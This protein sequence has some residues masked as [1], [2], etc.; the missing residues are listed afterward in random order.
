MDITT[1]RTLMRKI[2]S[3]FG[4]LE[5]ENAQ[6]S[7]IERDLMLSY[8]RQL[9][10]VFLEGK[11]PEPARGTIPPAEAPREIKVPP[12]QVIPP[13]PAPTPVP[14]AKVAKEEIPAPPPPPVMPK[15]DTVQLPI[16]TPQG[17]LDQLF[18]FK[19]VTELSERLG[20]SPVGDLN[21]AMSINDRL[22]Y[23]NELFGRDR[24]AL[25]DSLTILNRFDSFTAAKNFL[26]S[27][28]EQYQWGREERSEVAQNFIKLVKRRYPA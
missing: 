21:T 16:G 17:S 19:K 12:V 26:V 18:T 8:L 13:M 9:Y 1:A 14:V 23:V 6:L 25:D 2:N 20:E 3:L 4:S 11:T 10:A 22:L 15:P 24:S 28:A 5:D 7:P 27:L